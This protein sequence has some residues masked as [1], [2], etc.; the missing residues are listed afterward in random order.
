METDPR[1]FLTCDAFRGVHYEPIV[2]LLST[3]CGVHSGKFGVR[4]GYHASFCSI[5]CDA[6]TAAQIFE[7]RT[8]LS[9]QG[10]K[11]FMRPWDRR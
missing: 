10:K 7:Q 4:K 1:L 11:C 9:F 5:Y 8:N 6:E 2:D 3:I